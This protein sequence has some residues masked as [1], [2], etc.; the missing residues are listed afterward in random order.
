MKSRDID[1]IRIHSEKRYKTYME[2]KLIQS[3][4]I[5]GVKIY[6]KR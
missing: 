1:G 3:G 4:D 2:E 6:I 5:Y